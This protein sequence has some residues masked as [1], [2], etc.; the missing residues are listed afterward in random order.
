MP[1]FVAVPG[2]PAL[3]PCKFLIPGSHCNVPI[4]NPISAVANDAFANMAKDF[5]DGAT[6]LLTSFAKAFDTLTSFDLSGSG[7]APIYAL[8][9]GIAGF[10]AVF[11]LISQAVRTAVSG[12]GAHAAQGLV[13]LAKFVLATGLIVAVAG[14]LLTAADQLTGWINQVDAGGQGQFSE[15]LA[16]VFKYDPNTA[17]AL[18]LI[19]GALGI[20][21]VL[22]LWLE[23][24]FRHAA[25]LVL[26]ATSPIAA[27]GQ[28][29]GSTGEWWRK[30][31][32]STVQ[33]IFLKP[34]IALVFAIGFEVAGTSDDVSNFLAGLLILL[35]AV[36]AWPTIAALFTFTSTKAEAAGGVGALLGFAAGKASGVGAGA[37]VSPDQMGQF[38][39]QRTAERIDAYNADHGG[40]I[41]GG[42][43]RVGANGGAPGAGSSAPATAGKAAAGGK[44]GAIA[45]G[46]AGG[47]VL[48]FAVAASA[49]SAV[50]GAA[51]AGM[52]NTSA[53]AGLSGAGQHPTGQSSTARPSQAPASGSGQAPSVSGSGPAPVGPGPAGGMT[54]PPMVGGPPASAPLS[55][56][57]AAPPPPVLPAGPTL[58]VSRVSEDDV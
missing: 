48:P 30:T 24:L 11:L 8:S 42:T 17:P 26:I 52:Q 22:V 36:V 41:G 45:G 1:S 40:G 5:A 21:V 39:S 43:P 37:G 10:L 3:D 50:T 16:S 25:I 19:F 12:Q 15:R 58:P 51:K 20:L 31:A 27:V 49:A 46:G 23:M 6:S 7:L 54:V 38:L 34:V 4:P 18:L 2:D 14:A 44:A 32:T 53:H 57:P 55:P 9:L 29:G 13:G 33:L 56:R 47:A 28:I 35:L